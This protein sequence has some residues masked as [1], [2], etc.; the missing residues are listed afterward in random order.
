MSGQQW[1]CQIVDSTRFRLSFLVR[2]R[3]SRYQSCIESVS[4]VTSS[5]HVYSVL[6][7]CVCVLDLTFM[8][9]AADIGDEDIELYVRCSMRTCVISDFRSRTVIEST[10]CQG[11]NEDAKLSIPSAFVSVPFLVRW[12]FS[13][14]QSC[15]VS[16]S[17]ICVYVYIYIPQLFVLY[18]L[19]CLLGGSCL[20]VGLNGIQEYEH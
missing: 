5:V 4:P 3:F 20:G 10:M 16:V 8:V 11:S 9:C 2:W 12:R 15:I 1:R 18:C 7:I 6:I 19:W 14:H 17:S 13:R